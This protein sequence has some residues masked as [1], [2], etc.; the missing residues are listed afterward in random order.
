MTRLLNLIK[1][2]YSKIFHKKSTYVM[3]LLLVGF[4]LFFNVIY[5]FASDD[6]ETIYDYDQ[7]QTETVQ[8]SSLEKELYSA[9]GLSEK[10]YQKDSFFAYIISDYQATFADATTDSETT[11]T[12]ITLLNSKDQTKIIDGYLDLCKKNLDKKT[13][14]AKEY[15]FS[16]LKEHNLTLANTTV[17]SNFSEFQNYY[18]EYARSTDS[19]ET[20]N[21][22]IDNLKNYKLMEYVLSH[23]EK[24]TIYKSSE[25]EQ[26]QTDSMF[27]RVFNN[28]YSALTVLGIFMIIIAGGIFASEFSG[29][30]IKFLVLNPVKRSK[31]FWSKFITC[32][33]LS[34]FGTI[35]TYICQLIIISIFNGAS[36]ING[37][38]L[39]ANSS[40][41]I[42]ATSMLL[43]VAIT[44]GYT[45]IGLITTMTLSFMISSLL[46]STAVA[47]GLSIGVYFTGNT[48]TTIL[49]SLHQDW[50][51]YLIFANTDLKSIVNGTPSFPN[52]TLC[53]AVVTIVIYMVIFLLTAYDAFVKREI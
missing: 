8:M 53:F 29:G 11:K 41:E 39:T 42:K 4:V 25:N 49:Q 6:S 24:A 21:A 37:V 17:Y 3:I 15:V 35:L 22:A 9:C 46:N 2:E 14:Q 48:A 20:E 44:Y 13:A 52:Q 32:I 18:E 38:F 51:R 50:G 7:G 27:L 26:V 12:F 31:I 5:R 10:D 45:L 40:G 16:F 1:N 30:T 19:Q 34:F 33:S 28:S 47:V 23:P 43:Y 36:D